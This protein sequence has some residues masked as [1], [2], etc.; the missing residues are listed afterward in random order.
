[1]TPPFAITYD[2]LCPFAR[3]ASETIAEALRDG[4]NFD[5]SFVPFSLEESHTADGEV[6]Q[7]D[8]PVSDLGPGVLA[9]LWSIAVRDNFPDSFLGFHVAMF[10]ARHDDGANISDPSV[11]EAVVDH[12]GLEADEIR[13]LVESGVPAKILAA[14][15]TRS[16]EEFSVFG[17]PT[18]IAGHE[19]VFVR[20]M[21]RHSIDDLSRVLDMLSWT[22]LN[23]F[24]RTT[25]PR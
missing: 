20:F 7:W 9:L 12:V 11:I 18:F 13:E 16:V 5:V 8:L 24:K 14:E 6:H 15:H 23:E 2:Y 21:E 3:N 4:A 22:N 19:A 1:M 25:V 10:S 17:V